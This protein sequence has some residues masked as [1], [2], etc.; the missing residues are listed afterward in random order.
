MKQLAVVK[1]WLKLVFWT[2]CP[3]AE[4]IT[5]RPF[6]VVVCVGYVPTL[7]V[8]VYALLDLST[9]CVTLEPLSVYLLVSAASNQRTDPATLVGENCV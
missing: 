3:V 7:P 2:N 8:N 6:N 5:G 9:I 1:F 4:L